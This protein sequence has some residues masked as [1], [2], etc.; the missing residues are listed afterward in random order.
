MP[1]QL[2]VIEF[3]RESLPLLRQSPVF[4]EFANHHTN[5]LRPPPVSVCSVSTANRVA[6]TLEQQP[7]PL[8]Q[9]TVATSVGGSVA[10]QT[11]TQQQPTFI[12][13][14]QIPSTIR[15]KPVM[16]VRS[17]RATPAHTD[18]A[19]VQVREIRNFKACR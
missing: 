4:K 1:L 16:M 3:L 5:I 8:P 19:P 15:G 17:L 18:P 9:L 2:R 10:T 6:A 14:G 13:R 12:N 7:Q 11:M